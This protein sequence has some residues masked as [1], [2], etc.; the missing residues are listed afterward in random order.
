MVLR[1][2]PVGGAFVLEPERHVD[3]RG[4]FARLWC[5]GELA[6]RGLCAEWVQSSV[7]FNRHP[8]TLRGMHLQ[9]PPHEE[10]KLVRCIAGSIHDVL[11]DVRPDSATCGAWFGIQLSAESALTLY[12]PAGVAHGFL[13][14]EV[15]SVVEYHMS[16]YY[17]PEAAIGFRWDDPAFGIQ[18][19]QRPAV[20]SARDA[21]FPDFEVAR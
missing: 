5:A 10:V 20:I 4:Y 7:S 14:L 9:A 16:T 1:E 17:A 12:V 21:G 2:T 15:D 6:E 13:T 8:A 19:P 18:W 11:V 3:E